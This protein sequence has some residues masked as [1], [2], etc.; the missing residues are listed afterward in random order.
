MPVQQVM[1]V[2]LYYILLHQV[3]ILHFAAS[4]GNLSLVILLVEKYRSSPHQV[5][6][7]G[8][9]PL[10]A[11]GHTTI[12]KYFIEDKAVDASATSSDGSTVLHFAALSGNLSLVKLLVEKYQSSPHHGQLPLHASAENGHTTI[13]KYFIEDKAVDTSV[14]NNDGGTV[15][16]SAV[17]SGNVQLVKYLRTRCD[18]CVVNICGHSC[19]HIAAARIKFKYCS[20][21]QIVM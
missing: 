16:H 19:Y 1:V 5:N 11:S 3:V 15:L 10:H 17:S 13:V 14:T 6:N 20:I 7:N 2:V 9:S 8:W 18:P 21:C 12:V 4:S